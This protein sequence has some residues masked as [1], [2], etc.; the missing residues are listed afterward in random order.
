MRH[1]IA[2]GLVLA[3][4]AP[5]YSAIAGSQPQGNDDWQER[6]LFEPKPAELASE[7]AGR[8]VI[9]D[10]L[11]EPQVDKAMD[12]AFDRIEH[13]M[14]IRVKV[15]QPAKTEG[16]KTEYVTYNDGC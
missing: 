13:M 3:F 15:P 7:A 4:S 12:Q 2:F 8:V 14:F 16:A 5:A 11:T 10:G 9:Y 6:R 1:A